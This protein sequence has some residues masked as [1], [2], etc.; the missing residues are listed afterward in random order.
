MNIKKHQHFFNN[1]ILLNM[2]LIL[3]KREHIV[4]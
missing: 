4:K 1:T 2:L 3:V